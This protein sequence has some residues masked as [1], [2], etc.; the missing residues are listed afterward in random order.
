MIISKIP[1]DTE[2]ERQ[3]EIKDYNEAIRICQDLISKEAGNL[4]LY[5]KL[6]KLYRVIGKHFMALLIYIDYNV[7]NSSHSFLTKEIISTLKYIYMK[8]IN[9]FPI[10]S[11]KFSIIIP[12]IQESPKNSYMVSDG[13]DTH[14]ILR[15]NQVF[16][17]FINKCIVKPKKIPH[18][19]SVLVSDVTGYNIL[20]LSR[21]LK[22]MKSNQFQTIHFC[23]IDDFHFVHIFSQNLL[24]H[25]L[26]LENIENHQGPADIIAK[27][28]TIIGSKLKGLNFTVHRA[29]IN[30]SFENLSFCF[31]NKPRILITGLKRGMNLNLDFSKVKILWLTFEESIEFDLNTIETMVSLKKLNLKN[32]KL[33]GEA[34]RPRNS[35]VHMEYSCIFNLKN[36]FSLIK[37]SF[38][39]KSL[40]F[41]DIPEVIP[42]CLMEFLLPI[43]SLRE[44]VIVKSYV[45]DGL[46]SYF[47]EKYF[48]YKKR[49]LLGIVDSGYR[50]IIER[51]E[52]MYS[53]KYIISDEFQWN[54]LKKKTWPETQKE[55][56]YR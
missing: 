39:L 51:L 4:K 52:I 31:T 49:K 55:W 27:R 45:G 30:L 25:N 22:I 34:K 17:S 42:S 46:A 11:S 36:L 9:I 1:V 23:N 38:S 14:L 19:G 3:I 5:L 35:I 12:H 28:V 6:G 7:A 37:A 13:K 43:L 21:F 26:L 20:N 33:I 47:H 24:F 8:S 18:I 53:N 44:L 48:K 29:F 32:C 40:F 15:G 10:I 41:C 2:W 16:S 56:Y 54:E 50:D